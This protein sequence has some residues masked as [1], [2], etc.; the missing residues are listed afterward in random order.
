MTG[1]TRWRRRLRVLAEFA[2]LFAVL[3]MLDRWLTGGTAFA[4]ISPN[5]YGLPVLVMALAYGTEAGLV[6]AIVSTAIWL[7][8]GEQTAPSGDYL[9]RLL[10][11]SATPLFWFV[12]ATIIGE[13]TNVRTR[14][15]RRLRRDRRA[16]A[17]DAARL[18]TAYQ[19]L[20]DTNRAL[21]VRLATD[22]ASPGR[23]IALATAAIGA[24]VD[25]RRAA[26]RDL[27]A[28]ATRTDDFTCYRIDPEHG[29]RVW[30]RG[31]AAGA[32]TDILPQPLVQRLGRAGGPLTVM[33]PEDRPLLADI[34]IAAVPLRGTG[35]ALIG[36]LVVHQTR[37]ATMGSQTVAEFAEIATW[38]P[39]VLGR[40]AQPSPA[41]ATPRTGR[42]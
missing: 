36:C 35:G 15:I 4:A 27:L 11:L 30:L 6:A 42:G 1:I 40:G 37:F 19:D 26:L 18:D 24:P 38:L 28:A 2:I 23:V 41:A 32:R 3:V 22:T 9:D 8:H 25:Q 31:P 21:Q 13:V 34:G 29:A 16:A 12:V 33:V 14:R 39:Q 17:A 5:P 7:A 10:H 20:V